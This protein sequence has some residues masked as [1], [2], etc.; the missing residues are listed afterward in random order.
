MTSSE[1]PV[2]A[3]TIKSKV[4]WTPTRQRLDLIFSLYR[5]Y[6]VELAGG[7]GLQGPLEPALPEYAEA[8]DP[9]LIHGEGGSRMGVLEARPSARDEMMTAHIKRVD[10]AVGALPAYQREL[11]KLRFLS[12]ADLLPTDQIVLEQLKTMRPNWVY[13]KRFYDHQKSRALWTLA[14]VFGV[15]VT[16]E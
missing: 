15:T 7:E 6:R 14:S 8:M 13:Q 3:E 1:S 10:S 4:L 9:D 2:S 12:V 16:E 5:Q 11:I